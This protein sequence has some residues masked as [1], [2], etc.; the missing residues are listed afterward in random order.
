LSDK[1]AQAEPKGLK[2]IR[3]AL[4]VFIADKRVESLSA[5]LVR[6]YERELGRLASHCEGQGREQ[7][8]LLALTGQVISA[9]CLAR[10]GASKGVRVGGPEKQFVWLSPARDDERC[11]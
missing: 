4:N 10:S 5:D 9:E 1:V 6:K 8:S 7:C 11:S 3:A 2:N